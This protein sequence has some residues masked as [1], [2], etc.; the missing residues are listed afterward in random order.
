M[1]SN[2]FQTTDSA[3]DQGVYDHHADDFPILHTSTSTTFVDSNFTSS[4]DH[5]FKDLDHDLGQS[6]NLIDPDLM[7]T[8]VNHPSPPPAFNDSYDL[9]I[10]PPLALESTLLKP[11]LQS[12]GPK[13]VRVNPQSPFPPFSVSKATRQHHQHHAGASTS[14]Q[15]E[16][17]NARTKANKPTAK[18]RTTNT[19]LIDFIKHYSKPTVAAPLYDLKTSIVPQA[20]NPDLRTPM[21]VYTDARIYKIEKLGQNPILRLFVCDVNHEKKYWELLRGGA[22]DQMGWID[23][24][25]NKPVD[26]G[27]S[28]TWKCQNH[29]AIW[30]VSILDKLFEDPNDN[31]AASNLS[32][33]TMGTGFDSGYMS[34]SARASVSHRNGPS[35]DS[36]TFSVIEEE[37]SSDQDHNQVDDQ[38]AEDPLNNDAINDAIWYAEVRE[39]ALVD[40]K[41]GDITEQMMADKVIADQMMADQMMADQVM[42]NGRDELGNSSSPEWA[43]TLL[44]EAELFIKEHESDDVFGYD[45]DSI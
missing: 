30:Q 44:V 15:A 2:T 22:V 32:T 27:K 29:G 16:N 40:L 9:G 43:D 21:L 45:L 28:S 41:I 26:A 4:F 39:Q 8:S 37:Q 13:Y 1:S 11:P 36:D 6:D 12:F 5:E 17:P 38:F 20:D 35:V 7:E 18:T 24:L 31:G 34:S 42:A 25:I 14:A 23:L 3:N 19:P 33:P 10:D